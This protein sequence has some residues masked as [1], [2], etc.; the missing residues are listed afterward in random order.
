M[1]PHLRASPCVV[2]NSPGRSLYFTYRPILYQKVMPWFTVHFE[3]THVVF[4][5]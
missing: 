4:D 5:Q 2:L 1:R 3:A